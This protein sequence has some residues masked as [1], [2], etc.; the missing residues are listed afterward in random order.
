[1]NSP[2]SYQK[3]GSLLE[4]DEA[5]GSRRM[6]SIDEQTQCKKFYPEEEEDHSL[7]LKNTT[8]EREK[9]SQRMKWTPDL[10]KKFKKFVHSLGR[11]ANLKLIPELMIVPNLN[12]R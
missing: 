5:E 2:K 7:V 4:K 1:M 3:N 10:E 9:T 8:E 6:R 11:K 12:P